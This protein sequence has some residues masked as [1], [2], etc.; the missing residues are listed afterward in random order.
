M[1]RLVND[2]DRPIPEMRL[3]P[4]VPRGWVAEPKSIDLPPY[5]RVDSF[6][7]DSISRLRSDSPETQCPCIENF[8]F[9]PVMR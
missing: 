8:R 3:E 4:P 7:F 9:K 1:I 2:G 5:G 6:L